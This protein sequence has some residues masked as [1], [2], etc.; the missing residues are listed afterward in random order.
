MDLHTLLGAYSSQGFARVPGFLDD[1][2][3][4]TMLRECDALLADSPNTADH[5]DFLGRSA[6]LDRAFEALLDRD[7][8]RGFLE[9]S[10]GSGYR[11]H[12]VALRRARPGADRIRMHQDEPGE[13]KLSIL[14]TDSDHKEGSTVFVPGSH[15]WP[16][17][18]NCLPVTPDVVDGRTQGTV[19]RAGDVFMFTGRV[20]H[21]RPLNQKTVNTVLLISFLPR[22]TPYPI[23]VP[24]PGSKAHFGPTLNRLLQEQPIAPGD[25]TPLTP[26]L[27]DMLGYRTRLSATSPWHLARLIAALIETPI[28]AIR[29]W[30]GHKPLSP[31]VRAYDDRLRREAHRHDAIA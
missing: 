17:I 27:E 24:A 13:T 25:R 18:L 4:A 9:S 7:L 22:G 21:G 28:Q 1:D 6:A 14:L 19:G 30:R 2:T 29:H 16:R 11:L 8:I 26:E 23:R 15:K 10:L 5:I 3:V 31:A 20:W 12:T